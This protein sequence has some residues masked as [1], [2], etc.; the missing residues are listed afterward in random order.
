MIYKIFNITFYDIDFKQ[1]INTKKKGLVI[2]PSGP[3]LS[4]IHSDKI[5]YESIKNA[6]IALF[7][8]GYFVLLLR[9]M[10]NLTVSKFSGYKFL[11]SF[12]ISIRNKKIFSIEVNK[13]LAIKNMN[14]LKKYKISLHK[15]QYIAPIYKKGSY[16]RDLSLLKILKKKRPKIILINL[17]GGTQEVLGSYLKNNLKYKPLIICS[18][19]AISFFT[20]QQAPINNFF[21]TLYLGW[22]IRCIFNPVVFLPRYLSAF[23]LFFHVLSCDVKKI[24]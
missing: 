21:D 6:D 7:D 15:N 9:L 1:F 11:K 14:Y 18:G 13:E 17:G 23:K 16:I 24:R 5:Y 20:K 3:G 10:K 19:A 12:F 4:T 22:L 2:L 8:S